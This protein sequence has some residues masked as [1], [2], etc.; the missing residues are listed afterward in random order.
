MYVCMCMYICTCMYI[1]ID[2]ASFRD[3]I[4][5]YNRKMCKIYTVMSKN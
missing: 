4:S 2:S 5:V 1:K 3:F